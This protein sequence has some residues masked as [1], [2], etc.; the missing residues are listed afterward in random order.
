ML[1]RI[2]FFLLLTLTLGSVKAQELPKTRTS[3]LALMTMR[4][5]DCYVKIVYSQPQKRGREVF[6]DLVPYGKVW[7]LGANEATE[8]TITKNVLINSLLLKE[9]TYS[10]FAIP[11]KD[12]W[13]IIINSELGLWGSYNYNNKL[14]VL[15]FDVPVTAIE[16]T[17]VEALTLQFDQRNDVADLLIRWEKTQ[18]SI[19]FKFINL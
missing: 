13:T 16:S 14:D 5:K 7:R 1:T 17:Q 15:R 10:L 3:P 6:G 18:V 12:K 19:P 8:I 2:T 11:Q 4:F 9:G